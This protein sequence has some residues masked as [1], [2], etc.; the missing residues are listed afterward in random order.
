MQFNV[1]RTTPLLD[2]LRVDIALM[3]DI[4]IYLHSLA[5]LADE[6]PEEPGEPEEPDVPVGIGRPLVGL[7]P[8]AAPEPVIFQYV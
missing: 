5:K 4:R 7:I 8:P 2:L 6:E 1:H 3:K